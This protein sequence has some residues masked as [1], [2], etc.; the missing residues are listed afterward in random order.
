MD[1]L[2]TNIW[3]NSAK[4]LRKLRVIVL[5]GIMGALSIVLNYAGSVRIGPFLK[6]GLGSVPNIC[7][8]FM[9]GPVVGGI[10]GGVMDFLKYLTN[11]D[12]SFFPGFMISASAAAVIYGIFLYQKKLT[13]WRVL[14]PEILVKA[15]I[16]CGLNTLWLNILYG[17][18]FL[19]ILP[20][21][22]V[23]NAIQLPIDTILMFIILEA[24]DK[25][26]RKYWQE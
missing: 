18:G 14:I 22:I 16:N 3:V 24:V 7:V 6:I 1:T 23:S 4:E 11:P 12:G 2:S 5:C 19:A 8:D 9:F 17:K 15:F 26:K 10:F 21:R 13:W 20:G 25:V